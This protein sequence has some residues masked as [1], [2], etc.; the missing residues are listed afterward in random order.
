MWEINS[1]SQYISFLYSFIMG[2]AM[3]FIYDIFRFDRVLF[4]RSN[5]FVFIQDI[6]FWLIWAFV[7]FSFS[8]VF[9]NGQIRG[10]LLVG[11]FLGFLFFRLTFSRL[12]LFFVTPIKKLVK[13][14]NVNYLKGIEKLFLFINN[15]IKKS[16]NTFKKIFCIKKQKI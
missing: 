3:G 4:K 12:F 5:F 13:I 16:R 2:N 14:L 1:S 15:I 9:A 11:S 8:V 10:Y 7:F 6:F